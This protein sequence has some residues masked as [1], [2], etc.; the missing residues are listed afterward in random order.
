MRKFASS[1][2]NSSPELERARERE[3]W[4]RHKMMKTVRSMVDSGRSGS[5]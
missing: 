1:L 4:S 2:W 3:A 5:E